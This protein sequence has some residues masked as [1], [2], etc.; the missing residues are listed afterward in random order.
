M[1]RGVPL[2]SGALAQWEGQISV[3]DPARG[4]PCYRCIFPQAPAA[5]LAPSCAEA[6]V[7]GPLPGV[8]GAMMAAEAVKVLT[9]AGTPM[10]GQML[11]Y[12]ALH[13]ETR[14]IR[15]RTAGG[16]PRLR[17]R[18]GSAMILA[19]PA[20][21]RRPVTARFYCAPLPVAS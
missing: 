8:L 4:A 15:L 5:E 18:D 21:A 13:G 1:A 3:F 2:I 11:I 10:R 7:L 14:S 17:W 19:V 6:G 12:D 16:L 9:G 20:A